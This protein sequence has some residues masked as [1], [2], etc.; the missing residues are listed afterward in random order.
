[1]TLPKTPLKI[2][3][4]KAIADRGYCSRRA[5]ETLIL[6]GKVFVNNTKLLTP[7]FLVSP[8]DKIRIEGKELFVRKK[9]RLWCFYK[10]KG[11]LTSHKDPQGRPTVFSFLKEKFPKMPRVISVGR[12]DLNSEGLLILTTS[13]AL[14]HYMELPKTKWI[15][16]YRV[17]VFGPLDD[18]IL[19]SIKKG[20]LENGILYKPHNI[21]LEKPLK[22][23]KVSQN[24][25]VE[26][27]LVTGKNREVRKLFEHFNLQVNRLIRLSYGPF[28][29]ENLKPGACKEIYFENLEEHFPKELLDA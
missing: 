26:I 23:E 6:E 11:L 22:K 24:N 10:P 20:V 16:T 1:M 12:L 3:I 29:L 17:R 27:S 15:R 8:E 28:V 14:A 7:A 9:P 18:T 25:W 13:G 4:A 2:R 21:Q 5:A 19:K